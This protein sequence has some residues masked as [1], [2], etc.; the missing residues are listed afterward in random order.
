MDKCHQLCKNNPD[1]QECK[2]CIG[3]I[4]GTQG[5]IW[6]QYGP[7]GMPVK[8]SSIVEGRYFDPNNYNAD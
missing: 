5:N 6:H 3:N 2:S 4:Q 1:S 8:D 7:S